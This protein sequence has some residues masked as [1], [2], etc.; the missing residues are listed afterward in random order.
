M[1]ASLRSE[2]TR[3]L[4]SKSLHTVSLK[5]ASVIESFTYR[6]NNL[7]SAENTTL[8]SGIMLG[9]WK[10]LATGLFGHC[11]EIDSHI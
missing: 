6:I 1:T 3:H 5:T 7:L 4:S 11:A 9:I 2:K 10:R 8:K